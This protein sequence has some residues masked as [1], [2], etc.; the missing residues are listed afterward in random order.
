M[1]EAEGLKSMALFI[2]RP[3]GFLRCKAVSGGAQAK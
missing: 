2:M 3:T 1:L